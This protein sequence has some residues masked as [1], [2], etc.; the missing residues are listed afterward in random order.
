MRQRLLSGDMETLG[1]GGLAQGRETRTSKLQP[2]LDDQHPLR[3]TSE[4]SRGLKLIDKW[5]RANE[6]VLFG[7]EYVD[8]QRGCWR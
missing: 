4:Q 2:G 6:S 8:F 3:D 5:R 7:T 1:E